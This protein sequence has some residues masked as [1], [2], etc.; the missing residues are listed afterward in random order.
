MN[1]I[2][3][4]CVLILFGC[5][6]IPDQSIMEKL[7]I[8]DL[9]SAIKSDTSFASFYETIR[10]K[11]DKLDDIKKA[12]YHDITYSRLF[13]YVRFLKDTAY[14]NPLNNDWEKE[15]EAQFGAYTY[16]ADSIID[17]WKNYLEENSLSKYVNVE[18]AEIDLEYYDYIG[19]IKE[20]NLG[21]RLT[22]LQGPIQQVRFDYGYKAK[23]HGDN[24]YFEKHKCISTSP[25]NNQTVRYW[26]VEYSEREKF[27]GHSVESFLR[28]YFLFLEVTQIRKDGKNTSI[29]DF[30]I[31]DKVKE[32]LEYEKEYPALFELSKDALIKELI[33]QNYSGKWTFTAQKAAEIRE[34]KDKLCFDFLDSLE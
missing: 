5:S 16:K 4:V 34:S 20:V 1:R 3:Y 25:F 17:F 9:N 18:L 8:E 12:T 22:P 27:S 24:N 32:C 31:P 28:D 2:L 6:S 23:I 15:W 11:T 26:E 21:F 7:T 29:D 33:D 14:W 30:A 19:G 10:A 13:E